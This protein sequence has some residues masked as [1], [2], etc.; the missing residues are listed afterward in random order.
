MALGNVTIK[1]SDFVSYLVFGPGGALNFVIPKLVINLEN[2]DFQGDTENSITVERSCFVSCT[3]FAPGG[4]I[5]IDDLT[6][7]HKTT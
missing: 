6:A 3:A 4:A 5:L 1:N 2:K 7:Q